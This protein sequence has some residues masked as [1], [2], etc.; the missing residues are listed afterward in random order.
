MFVLTKCSPIR[1]PAS[2]CTDEI[3]IPSR[4]HEIMTPHTV[5]QSDT[6]AEPLSNRTCTGDPVIAPRYQSGDD[7]LS[8]II[9]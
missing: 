6:G 4:T 8:R 2:S 5:D 9:S 3:C 7:A 1:G